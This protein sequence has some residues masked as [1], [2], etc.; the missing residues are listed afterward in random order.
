MPGVASCW[1]FQAS[2]GVMFY[3]SHFNS[4]RG[5]WCAAGKASIVGI[6][7]VHSGQV[8]KVK[9]YIG[10]NYLK[11]RWVSLRPYTSA[12]TSAHS[13]LQP[14]T[15]CAESCRSVH[16]RTRPHTPVH[17]RTRTKGEKP[18][19]N[20]E[21]KRTECTP[22]TAYTAV[23]GRTQ[24][25]TPYRPVH[26]NTHLLA[27]VHPLRVPVCPSE[28]LPAPCAL[29]CTPTCSQIP[30]CTSKCIPCVYTHPHICPAHACG[31]KLDI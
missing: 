24:P 9:S 10:N 25:C 7:M 17:P 5:S 26:I 14:Y 15:A 23:H 22:Y 1:L 19:Q 31:F 13:C 11:G 2:S 20:G 12:H 29:P 4:Y 3:P 30:M 6:I 18:R 16:D 27:P 28:H 21:K 8:L